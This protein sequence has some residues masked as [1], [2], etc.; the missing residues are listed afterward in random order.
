MDCVKLC[1]SMNQTLFLILM[2]FRQGSA[3]YNLQRESDT[4][5]PYIAEPVLVDGFSLLADYLS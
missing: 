3:V 5:I 4:K 2:S 1:Y